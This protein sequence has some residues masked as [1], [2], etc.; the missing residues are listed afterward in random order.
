MA[1]YLV[2]SDRVVDTP[3]G[4]VITASDLPAGV[5]FSALVE[6]GHLEIYEGSND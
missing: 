1:N 3:R 2:T 4:S 5:N 6:G